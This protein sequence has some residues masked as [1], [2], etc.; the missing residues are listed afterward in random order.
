V[1]TSCDA[2][3]QPIPS[4]PSVLPSCASE[5]APATS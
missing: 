4:V 2:D 3:T 1:A 5:F